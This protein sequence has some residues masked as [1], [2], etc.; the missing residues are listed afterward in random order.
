MSA[1]SKI[2][3]EIIDRYWDLRCEEG[4]AGFLWVSVKYAPRILDGGF[5]VRAQSTQDSHFFLIFSYR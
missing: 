2:Q 1:N 5:L 3:L 4:G